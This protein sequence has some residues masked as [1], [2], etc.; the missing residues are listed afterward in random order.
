MSAPAVFVACPFLFGVVT[1]IALHTGVPESLIAIAIGWITV[2]IAFRRRL[3][4]AF[5]FAAAAGS[6]AAGAAIG[7]QAERATSRSTLLEWFRAHPDRTD[8]VTLTGTLR[9]DA[10]PTANGATMT[11]D[12]RDVDAAR[13]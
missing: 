7:G 1:G 6:F 13:V 12:A 8:P 11:V 4:L 10:A 2:A 5:A 3:D 9:D